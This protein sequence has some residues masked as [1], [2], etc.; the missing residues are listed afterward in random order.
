MLRIFT[1]VICLTV[2]VSCSS[3]PPTEETSD[4]TCV[5]GDCTKTFDKLAGPPTE[6]PVAKPAK[7]KT[8]KHKR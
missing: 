7:P 5:A 6:Q 1:L 2:F 4:A 3:Q 8:K